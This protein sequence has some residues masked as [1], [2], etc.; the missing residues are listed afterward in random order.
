ME[1]VLVCNLGSYLFRNIP[2]REVLALA[3]TDDEENRLR[4]QL[5][6]D[7]KCTSV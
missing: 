1:N 7:Y 6:R 4:E 3:G 2:P 5:S